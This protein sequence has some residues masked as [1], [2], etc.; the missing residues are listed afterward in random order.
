MEKSMP[1]VALHQSYEEVRWLHVVED[2][3]FADLV[4]SCYVDNCIALVTY[5]NDSN[6]L[7]APSLGE[8]SVAEFTGR[9]RSLSRV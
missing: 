6:Y 8:A 3:G 4:R 7:G 2:G 5:L 9:D 1:G